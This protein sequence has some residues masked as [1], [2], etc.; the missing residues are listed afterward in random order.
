MTSLDVPQTSMNQGCSAIPHYIAPSLG[1]TASATL[2]T[3]ASAASAAAATS[4]LATAS[5][6]AVTGSGSNA[7]KKLA[8]FILRSVFIAH[9]LAPTTAQP[10]PATA[11]PSYDVSVLT[12]RSEG[13]A[14]QRAEAAA[15]A[16]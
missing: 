12:T 6:H 16:T 10:Q 13:A 9:E 2:R 7:I 8:T 14:D 11:R 5:R 3:R 4:V 15:V 1:K